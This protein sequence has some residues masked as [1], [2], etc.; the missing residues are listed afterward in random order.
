LHQVR[1]R[2]LVIVGEFDLVNPVPIA[3]E[4]VDELPDP[5]FRVM[6][7]VGHMPH[8]EDNP[9]FRQEVEAFLADSA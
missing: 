6:P 5:V 1:V 9:R 8:I 3:Q 2:S 4:L 7:N